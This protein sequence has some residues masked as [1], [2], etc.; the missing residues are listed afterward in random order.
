MNKVA[1]LL[2]I[3]FLITLSSCVGHK[4]GKKAPAG[5]VYVCTGPYARAYHKYREC[6]GLLKCSMDIELMDEAEALD[7]GL[8]LCSYCRNNRK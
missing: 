1:Y 7:C 4:R 6:E 3:L 5:K 8:H 2:L